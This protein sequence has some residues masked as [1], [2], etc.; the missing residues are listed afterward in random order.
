MSQRSIFQAFAAP[1]V[2]L[3]S[4]LLLAAGHATR[5]EAQHSSA[6]PALA[7]LQSAC[8]ITFDQAIVDYGSF[9]AGQLVLDSNR[10]YTLPP[11]SVALSIAC[12]TPRAMSLRLNA[13]ARHDGEAT[14]AQTGALKVE[15]SQVRVDGEDTRIVNLD[16]PY[17]PQTQAPMR[18]GDVVVMEHG[19]AGRTLTAQINL[20]PEVGDADVRVNDQTTWSTS[21][22]VELLDAEPAR[23]R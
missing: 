17:G 11:R 20:A 18:P 23:A 9:T 14:F 12:P 6:S 3:V 2:L 8:Q 1:S 22:L 21:L 4:A 15:L 5:A 19:R 16:M 7:P 13:P 10:L